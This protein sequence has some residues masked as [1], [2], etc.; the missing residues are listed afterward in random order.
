MI[1]LTKKSFDFNHDLNQ[2]LKS[3]RFKSA[4]LECLGTDL[5]QIHM[6]DMFAASLGGV[7]M[8]RSKVKVIRDKNRFRRS[9]H[10][11]QWLNGPVCCMQQWPWPLFLTFDGPCMQFIFGKNIFSCSSHSIW[12]WKLTDVDAYSYSVLSFVDCCHWQLLHYYVVA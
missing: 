1:L 3:A 4:N 10:P 5:R 8:S 9:H 6:E 11:R 12:C 2:W 7:W